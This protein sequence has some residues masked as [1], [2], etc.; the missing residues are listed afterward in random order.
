MEQQLSAGAIIFYKGKKGRK[1]LILKDGYGHWTFPKGI[2]EKTENPHDTSKREVKEETGLKNVEFIS[3]FKQIHQYMFS[4]EGDLISKR[5]L[6]YLARSQSK[7]VKLSEEHTDFKWCSLKTA[8]GFVDI[9]DNK[10]LLKKADEFLEIP[11][12]I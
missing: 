10:E 6:W 3:G 2:V 11:R 7:R 9:K 1:Y 4:F 5:V 8:V 12:L